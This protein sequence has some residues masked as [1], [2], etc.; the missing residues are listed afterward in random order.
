[1]CFS[2]DFYWDQIN[3]IQTVYS[4]VVPRKS[5]YT[6]SYEKFNLKVAKVNQHLGLETLEISESIRYTAE[7]LI[8]G[9]KKLRQTCIVETG[10]HVRY[11]WLVWW[12]LERHFSIRNKTKRNIPCVKVH[13]SWIKII[14]K[15]QSFFSKPCFHNWIGSFIANVRIP[16]YH[17]FVLRL[18]I[19]KNKRERKI[20]IT[21]EMV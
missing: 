12:K 11:N 8:D 19:R 16:F 5:V 15:C 9:W 18:S 4:C 6:R 10:F 20:I 13:I 21:G 14:H 3:T 17:I 7:T 2:I 1:M